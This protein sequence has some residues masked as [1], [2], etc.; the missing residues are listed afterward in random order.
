MTEF[1][2]TVII[3]QLGCI[4]VMLAILALGATR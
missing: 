2:G 4:C 3:V 1:Q